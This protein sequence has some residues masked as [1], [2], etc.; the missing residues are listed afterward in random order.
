MTYGWSILIIAVILGTLAYTG[1]FGG[2]S[3]LPNGCLSQTGFICRSPV[4][5]SNGL[6]SVQVG[7]IGSTMTVTGLGCS[8]S[9]NAPAFTSI[10]STQLAGGGIY[11]LSFSCR[12]QTNAIGSSFSGTLWIQYNS[13]TQSGLT[14]EIGA[15]STK[16]ATAGSPILLATHSCRSSRCS[17]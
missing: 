8:N 14:A 12:I 11:G 2:G 16:A 4:M 5:S 6:L 1:V 13:G 17:P 9:T 7:E 3:S 15:V 10:P